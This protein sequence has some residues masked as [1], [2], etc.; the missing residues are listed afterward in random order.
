MKPIPHI[1]VLT[2]NS[3]L[4]DA[5]YL[6][7]E[8]ELSTQ[9][10]IWALTDHCRSTDEFSDLVPAMHSLTLYLKS[11][12]NLNKWLQALPTLWNAIK[13][14]SF[15][16]R[17]HLIRTTYNGDDINYVANY[18]NLSAD[19]VINIHS[20]THY[21]VL[22]L[23]F[24]PGFAYLHGLDARLHTPRRNEPRTRV[25][26][27]SVAIGASHTGVYP[28]DT[29]GG[30]HIIAHTDT[31]LFDPTSA[32]PCLIQ[33]GDTLEFVPLIDKGTTHD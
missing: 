6:E 12:K 16:G 2:N 8:D 30:W 11:S 32:R 17:H 20:K 1:H 27:G 5:S 18:H 4:F 23:G 19:E 10:K 25:P 31:V 33:P 9:K 24:Q 13:S 14:S 26:K 22:F 3:L 7:A 21:Y 28:A 29:P 15:E